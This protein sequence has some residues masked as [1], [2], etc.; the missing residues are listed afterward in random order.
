VSEHQEKPQEPTP[1]TTSG[2]ATCGSSVALSETAIHVAEQFIASD[3]TLEDLVEAAEIEGQRRRDPGLAKALADYESLRGRL[4][5]LVHRARGE[6]RAGLEESFG[7]PEAAPQSVADAV[8]RLAEGVAAQAEQAAWET[9]R[10]MRMH[11]HGVESRTLRGEGALRKTS[12]GSK[13]SWLWLSLLAPG[14][15]AAC[16]MFITLTGLGLVQWG[17]GSSGIGKESV[18]AAS[19]GGER[20]GKGDLRFEALHSVEE[21]F[22]VFEEVS[23]FFDQQAG[24]VAV[25]GKRGLERSNVLDAAEVGLQAAEDFSRLEPVLIRLQML[26]P[27]GQPIQTDI[28]IRPGQEAQLVVPMNGHEVVYKLGVL[29]PGLKDSKSSQESAAPTRLQVAAVLNEQTQLA[30]RLAMVPG[31]QALAGRL[32]T[33]A[34]A[35]DLRVALVGDAR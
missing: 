2:D 29:A 18:L 20:N 4:A 31:D 23:A 32:V 27:A 22:A 6:L 1:I 7:I 30:T 5:G 21:S 33:E 34:G 14:A 24:W 3:W 17:P 16:L 8:E 10:A 35:Y 19:L 25:S 15:L 9:D 13:G 11:G 12:P 26:G 28:V